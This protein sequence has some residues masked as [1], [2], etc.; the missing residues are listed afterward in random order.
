MI[1]DYGRPSPRRRWYQFT[2]VELLII[3]GIIA[4][5]V[6]ILLPAVTDRPRGYQT[7]VTLCASNLR[8]IAQQLYVYGNANGAFPDALQTMIRDPGNRLRAFIFVCPT[9]PQTASPATSAAKLAKDFDDDP[10]A[11]LSYVYLGAALPF[12]PP[13]KAVLAYEPL[14]NHRGM[15]MNVLFADGHVEY[16][17]KPQ[18][19]K[20]IA[21]LN[22]GHNPPR[23]EMMK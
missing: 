9:S 11:Y 20:L 18:A 7:R 5:L 15:G 2:L 21:E 16:L 8:Q 14:A 4:L 6:G 10:A 12:P 1:L 3:I 23:A 17:A 13:A 19:D 22:S